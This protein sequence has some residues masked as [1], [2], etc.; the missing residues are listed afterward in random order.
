MLG[1]PYDHVHLADHRTASHW[2]PD[3][4]DD[5]APTPVPR[6]AATS[7]AAAIPV[8]PTVAEIEG[9]RQRIAAAPADQGAQRD[10][11][12]A[13]LQRARETLDPGLYVAADDAFAKADPTDPLVTLGRATLAAARHEFRAALDGARATLRE[14]PD[15]PPAH[16]IEVDALVELGRYDEADKVLARLAHAPPT[17]PILARAS[18]LH[19]LRGDLPGAI[20]RM[21]EAIAAVD[22]DGPPENLAYVTTLLGDLLA[23]TGDTDGA[24]KAYAEALTLAPDHV[25]ALLGQ[26]RLALRLGDLTQAIER[27]Q[28]AVDI[29]PTPE[30][31]VALGEA[32]Q[33]NGDR[34]AAPTRSPWPASR[35]SSS[36]ATASPSI[37][38]SAASRPTTAIPRTRSRQPSAPTG[39]VRP[40]RRPTSLPGRAS[41]AAISRAP[42]SRAVRPSGL[43]PP[44]RSC[45][46][47]PAPSRPPWATPAVRT[48]SSAGRWPSMRASPRPAPPTPA[49][50]A[51]SSATRP[52]IH[53]PTP[54]VQAA[55]DV[56]EV[57]TR[58][59]S[60]DP[61]APPGRDQGGRSPRPQGEASCPSAREPP[62]SR[63][64]SSSR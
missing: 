13:L 38:S 51:T 1:D 34:S 61:A 8:S 22:P 46:T 3:G 64:R 48:R 59:A 2:G 25:A 23:R 15:L 53:P 39:S 4:A 5:A 35:S 26:G 29:V 54:A 7:P 62:P 58:S 19:E 50:S 24:A 45:T 36:R 27:F 55:N 16:A 17:L 49:G 31:V 42:G 30:A 37:W 33:T 63:A 43:A 57:R 21:R 56:R 18:Y 20:E 32:E 44:T 40:S 47:T 9:L 11:G 12:F 52:F 10:L 60:T 41:A 28:H 14:L 6:P